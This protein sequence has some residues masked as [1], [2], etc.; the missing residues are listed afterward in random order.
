MISAR[1]IAFTFSRTCIGTLGVPKVPQNV[2]VTTQRVTRFLA[3][4][5]VVK[6]AVRDL[7]SYSL[8]VLFLR[9]F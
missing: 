2:L 4:D 6:T 8:K 7:L 3:Q 5:L 9:H 1:Y